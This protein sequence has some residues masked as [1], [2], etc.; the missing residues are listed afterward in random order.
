HRVMAGVEQAQL[1]VKLQVAQPLIGEA[2]PARDIER[3]PDAQLEPPPQPER[4][5]EL[6]LELVF[7]ARAHVATPGRDQAEREVARAQNLRS[8][9]GD[10]ALG[11]DGGTEHGLGVCERYIHETQKDEAGQKAHANLLRAAQP[12]GYARGKKRIFVS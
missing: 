8:V 10:V 11:I 7:D 5:L 9:D 6:G 1:A 3:D 4:R 2:G 12:A